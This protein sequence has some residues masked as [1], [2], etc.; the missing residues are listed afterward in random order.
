M[1]E[2]KFEKALERLKVIVSNLEKGDLALEESLQ[3]FEEGV[4]LSRYCSERLGDAER[5]IEV[6]VKGEG[7]VITSVPLEEET[8]EDL[9]SEE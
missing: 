8:V 2:K 6:L 5:R 4:N 3:L 1:S 9:T 7:E